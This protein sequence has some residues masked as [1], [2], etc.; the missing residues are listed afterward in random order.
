MTGAD[1]IAPNRQSS[2]HHVSRE[3]HLQPLFPRS[4]AASWSLA[5]FC[6]QVLSGSW[7]SRR[8]RRLPCTRGHRRW[9]RMRQGSPPIFSCDAVPG[10]V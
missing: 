2:P 4:K 10:G 8:G 5:R 6:R 7:V 1:R 3:P 9:S